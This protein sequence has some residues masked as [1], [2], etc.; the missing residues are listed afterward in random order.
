MRLPN[1]FSQ[2]T[3]NQYQEANRILK[4]DDDF[5]DKSVKLISILSGKSIEWI[6]SHTPKQI[7]DWYSSLGFLSDKSGLDQSK[8]K[9][10]IVANGRVYKA[11]INMDDFSAGQLIALKHFEEQSN[12][13]DFIHQ[14][15]ALVYMPIN[16]YGKAKKYDAK[17]HNKIS[18]D[19]KH[20]NLGDVYGLLLFKKKVYQTLSPIIDSS[21]SG[22]ME[23][24]Q[25][26]MDWLKQQQLQ[27]S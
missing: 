13:V 8:V 6:E 26:T 10:Y 5:L 18:E 11:V 20:A 3:V 16:W 21:L 27:T 7:G 25:E 12:P 17:L 4:S 9:P 2:L 15:L 24:I 22:A 14:Q 19:M 1:S 23:T